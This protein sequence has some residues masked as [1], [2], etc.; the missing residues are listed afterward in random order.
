MSKRAWFDVALGAANAG[1]VGVMDELSVTP[2][3]A[4]S[5]RRLTSSYTGSAIRVRRSSDNAEADI[6]FTAT[7]DLDETALLA[8]VGAGDGFVHTWYDQS[9]GGFDGVELTLGFQPRIVL[10]GVIDKKNSKPSCV[11]DNNLKNFPIPTANLSRDV[12]SVSMN[13]VV[14][15]PSSP[16]FQIN[17]MLIYINNGTLGS[18][19]RAG[20]CPNPSITTGDRLGLAYRRL[21]DDG[22]RTL[23]SSTVS[24]TTAAG[25]LFV[26]TGI[27]DYGSDLGSHY[28]NNA[29]D[30]AP[31]ALTL[32]AGPTSDTDPLEASIFGRVGTTSLGVPTDSTISECLIFHDALGTTD[33]NTLEQNQLT[34]YAI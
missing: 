32:G 5:V 10:S 23:S 27:L 13:A 17:A 29:E 15:Y 11:K 34:Y 22:Y 7:G 9:G 26:E 24:T 1:F 12:L 8:H 20:L 6:G 33:R 2:V 21:D 30:L 4:Y 16:S 14:F 3:R 25:A 28:F 18:R 31:T 19:T